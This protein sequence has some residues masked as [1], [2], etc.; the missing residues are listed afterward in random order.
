MGVLG[1][2]KVT[3]ILYGD[4]DLSAGGGSGIGAEPYREPLSCGNQ[5]KENV[6]GGRCKKGS[7]AAPHGTVVLRKASNAT[8]IVALQGEADRKLPLRVGSPVECDFR[9]GIFCPPVGQSSPWLGA[10][11][12]RYAGNRNCWNCRKPSN[13]LRGCPAGGSPTSLV[14]SRRTRGFGTGGRGAPSS[15]FRSGTGADSGNSGRHGRLSGVGSRFVGSCSLL[16]DGLPR[17]GECRHAVGGAGRGSRF[18]LF[19]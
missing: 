15:S 10:H 2:G 11:G 13:G 12:R 5:H 18:G 1:P 16:G 6:G 9:G 19:R 7:G 17:L 3:S 4:C 14:C 8:D